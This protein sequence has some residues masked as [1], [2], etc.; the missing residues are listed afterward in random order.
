[1]PSWWSELAKWCTPPVL[2]CGIIL[3]TWTVKGW[4]DR[5]ESHESTLNEHASELKDHDK[6]IGDIER[7]PVISQ[8]L[9]GV[10]Q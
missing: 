3:G 6:R 10:R 7:V 2:I 1:M 8:N 4:V 9:R 5:L